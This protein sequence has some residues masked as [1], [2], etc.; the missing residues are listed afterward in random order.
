[1]RDFEAFG[2]A[3]TTSTRRTAGEPGTGGADIRRLVER[4]YIRTRTI[5]QAYDEEAGMF[6]PDRYVRAVPFVRGGRPVRRQ[7]FGLRRH[8]RTVRTGQSSFD[9]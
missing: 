3:S 9:P 6:L 2:I 8:L 1:M 4:G 5:Q 7:L